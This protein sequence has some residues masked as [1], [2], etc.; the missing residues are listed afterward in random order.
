MVMSYFPISGSGSR[1]SYDSFFCSTVFG[2][3]SLSCAFVSKPIFSST[4]PKA[5]GEGGAYIIGRLRR[6]SSIR[7]STVSNSSS[8]TTEPI[9]IKVHK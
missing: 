7:P 2:L 4:E 6:P 1:I 9:V 3:F 5:P 8:E